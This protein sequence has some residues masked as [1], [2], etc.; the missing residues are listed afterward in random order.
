MQLAS[1]LSSANEFFR[2][3]LTAIKTFMTCVSGIFSYRKLWVTGQENP[4][5]RNARSGHFVIQ[6]LLGTGVAI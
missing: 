1:N 2:V 5:E 3:E 4:R 6:R